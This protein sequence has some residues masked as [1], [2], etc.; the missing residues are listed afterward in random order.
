MD[1]KQ[2]MI[3]QQMISER[4][5]KER[6]KFIQISRLNVDKKNNAPTE[7]QKELSLSMYKGIIAA[8]VP[9][10][11]PYFVPHPDYPENPY[12]SLVNYLHHNITVNQVPLVLSHY[13]VKLDEKTFTKI[14]R[15]LANDAPIKAKIDAPIEFSFSY[16][17]APQCSQSPH[18]F[19]EALF[20]TGHE[21]AHTIPATWVKYDYINIRHYCPELKYDPIW[22]TSKLGLSHPKGI[23]QLEL[24]VDTISAEIG[25]LEALQG[26]I[27]WAARDIIKYER[28][29][30]LAKFFLPTDLFLLA[31]HPNPEDRLI[32]LI[33]IW[34][35]HSKNVSCITHEYRALIDS[36]SEWRDN[37]H[38]NDH[39]IK[40]KLY[41]FERQARKHAITVPT[42]KTYQILRLFLRAEMFAIGLSAAIVTAK[43]LRR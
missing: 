15:H 32:N 27:T 39:L 38:P 35:K 5:Q 29:N 10:L 33:K 6:N 25:G 14:S 11:K 4:L 26:G 30:P 9:L 13:K 2:T 28:R 31:I 40:E 23:D 22:Y 41:Q 37:P 8:F 21:M 17:L 1:D 3:S 34:R 20:I 43:Q 19:G 18:T 36:M 24:T 7:K 16:V 42:N 12:Y